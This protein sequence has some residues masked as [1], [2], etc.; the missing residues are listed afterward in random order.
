MTRNLTLS[1]SDLADVK[2]ARAFKIVRK[3][4]PDITLPE[5]R[6]C[7][8]H[9]SP[10]ANWQLA[11]SSIEDYV[12]NLN[13]AR[14]VAN[15]LQENDIQSQMLDND[16]GAE[17]RLA[18]L[19]SLIAINCPFLSPELSSSV[20]QFLDAIS[21]SDWFASLGEPVAEDVKVVNDYAPEATLTYICVGIQN[22]IVGAIMDKTGCHHAC[23][24]PLF[25]KLNDQLDEMMATK[26]AQSPAASPQF[27]PNDIRALILLACVEME[28]PD[29]HSSFATEVCNWITRGKL[30]IGWDGA[31]PDGKLVLT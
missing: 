25:S 9:P 30:P 5:I 27:D 14:D 26:L 1:L 4:N 18:D 10:V 23:L 24:T 29:G 8:S 20:S 19:D 12:A 31:F 21:A 11:S 15:E 2:I 6:Q 28:Y 13:T 16:T 3:L 7:S 22:S 17:L